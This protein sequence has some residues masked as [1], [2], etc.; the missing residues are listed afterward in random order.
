MKFK[1]EIKKV[2]SFLGPGFLVTVGFID[3]GNWASNLEGGSL[4]SYDLLWVI[5]LSTL[6]L[7]LIQSM[8]AK[9]GIAS[10]KS[11]AVNIRQ[12]FSKPVLGLV[13]TT[14]ILACVATDVAELLGGAIGFNLLFK[15]PL[16]LGALLTVALELFFILGQRYHKL[17][18]LIIGF[19]GVIA[20]C[21]VIELVI[22]KPVWKEV[23]PSFFVPRLNRS[24]IYVAMAM[25]GAV[26]MP[27]NIFL[28]SNVIHSRDWGISNEKKAQLMRYERFD[29]I[30]ALFLGLL[31]NASMIIVAARVFHGEG[32]TITSIEEASK[33]LR[34]LAGPLAALLFAVALVF[35]GLG[36][37]ITSSMAEANVITGFLGKPEDPK[38]FFYRFATVITAVPSF[39]VIALGVDTYKILIF[40]QVILSIQL[41]FTLI[42][43]L[44]LCRRSKVMGPFRIKNLEFF[45]A[46]LT[47]ALVIALNIYLLYATLHGGAV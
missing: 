11:L 13:G 10:G 43:L 9:L 30:S 33:T 27:H 31:V 22:V 32:Q 23:L 36:S 7:V 44:I 14:V 20:L 26:V 35:S 8:A 19:L 45:L 24:S 46:L 12:E 28:H 25:L 17:E 40:S 1:P 3:P 47:T 15:L 34:P 5:T 37:S 4:Y 6:M 2:L 21:Y 42:P 18:R 38:S 41:P 29:T 39:I 16:G